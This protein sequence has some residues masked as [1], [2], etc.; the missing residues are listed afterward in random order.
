MHPATLPGLSDLQLPLIQAPMPG[1]IP[2][3]MI[4]AISRAGALGSLGAAYLQP[5]VLLELAGQVR[6][7]ADGAPFA[8]NLFVLPDSFQAEKGAVHRASHLLRQLAEHEGIAYEAAPG[9]RWAPVFSDQLAALREA[10]PAVAS[11]AFGLLTPSQLAELHALDI[12]VIGTATTVAEARAWEALGADAICAQGSEAGGHRGHFLQPV[13]QSMIG[14]MSLL[15][16]MRRAVSLP[17][18]AA[19]GLMTGQA[20][21]AAELLGASACQLGTAF[22]SCPEASIAEGWK[23]D[24]LHARDSDTVVTRAFSGRCARSLRN[25]YVDAL[26]FN[27]AE[28]PAFPVMNALSTPLR[29]AAAQAGR[30]DLVA[31]WAGQGVGLSRGLPVAELIGALMDERRAA[32]ASLAS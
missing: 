25:R 10:R 22:L 19:G 5:Q 30:A 31:E 11:F 16:Q 24:L 9:D 15:P 1:A 17:L 23:R 20:M 29:R 2:P 28:L 12:A 13:E 18:I 7:A 4:G 3:A 6:Q 32:K 8:I 26:R 21:A 14:L 27:E